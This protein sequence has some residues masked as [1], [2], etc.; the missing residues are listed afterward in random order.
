MTFIWYDM[1][2]K[3]RIHLQYQASDMGMIVTSHH[4]FHMKTTITLHTFAPPLEHLSRGLV[5]AGTRYESNVLASAHMPAQSDQVN[6]IWG[7]SLGR[8]ASCIARISQLLTFAGLESTKMNLHLE[9]FLSVEGDV[10]QLCNPQSLLL[11][12]LVSHLV[13]LVQ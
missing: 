3:N 4:L 6:I 12:L 2:S 10:R 7:S 8:N 9:S 1:P 5:F 11:L 13:L